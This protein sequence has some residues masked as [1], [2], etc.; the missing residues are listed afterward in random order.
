[1]RVNDDQTTMGPEVGGMTGAECVTI[2]LK[3]VY[4][5]CVQCTLYN[6]LHIYATGYTFITTCCLARAPEECS[7][8]PVLKNIQRNTLIAAF[9]IEFLQEKSFVLPAH[10]GSFFCL[11]LDDKIYVERFFIGMIRYRMLKDQLKTLIAGKWDK[12]TGHN[13]PLRPRWNF[14]PSSPETGT[15]VLT[16]DSAN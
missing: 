8:F 9:C 14:V 10:H 1:M 15:T 13:A 16:A 6:T 7:L 12:R 2:V 11:L 5:V 3:L 4:N